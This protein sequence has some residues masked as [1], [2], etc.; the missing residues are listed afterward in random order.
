M[1]DEDLVEVEEVIKD[2]PILRPQ[3]R[4]TR[5]LKSCVKLKLVKMGSSSL[6]CSALLLLFHYIAIHAVF[7]NR[8]ILCHVL[9][10][11]TTTTNH[12]NA[13]DWSNQ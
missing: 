5:R 7:D 12:K 4:V 9:F 8:H 2:I 3:Q 13:V 11:P 10:A 1:I 6:P